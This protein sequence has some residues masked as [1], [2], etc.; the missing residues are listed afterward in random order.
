M[1]LSHNADEN[2]LYSQSVIKKKKKALMQSR[3]L[4]NGFPLQICVLNSKLFP[5]TTTHRL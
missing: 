3:L 4:W 5:P 1:E 2:F